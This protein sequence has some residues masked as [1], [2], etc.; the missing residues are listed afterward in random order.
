MPHDR[1]RPRLTLLISAALHAG[2]LAWAIAPPDRVVAE[3]GAAQVDDRSLLVR[4]LPPPQQPAVDER[5]RPRPA[6]P[7][8]PLDVPPIGRPDIE[9]PGPRD[10][11]ATSAAPPAPTAEEWAFAARYT[12]KN[13][14]GYRYSWGQ[15]VRSQMGTA[16]AGPDQGV[17]RFRVEIAADG[18]LTRLD[19]LWTTS[20]VAEQRA[21]HAVEH[22]P[23][24]PPTPTGRP[25]VFE[26]TISFTPFGSDGPPVYRDDC[27]PD[28]PVF[29]NPF[30]WDG[31]STPTRA[32]P[33]PVDQPDP[34]A[35]AECLRQLPPDSVEAESA[36]DQRLREQWDS[37]LLRR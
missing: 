17:V 19:T 7:S 37:S 5:P 6:P 10:A 14:K 24:L 27:L 28:P 11:P 3:P 36:H 23:P 8:T 9:P 13:S 31:R 2:L 18:S 4:I 34:E 30:V 26:R 35:L 16:V 15:Q 25:L 20:V 22:M 32:E 1:A 12:L 33:K 29:R 21:R